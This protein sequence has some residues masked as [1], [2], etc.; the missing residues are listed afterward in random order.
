MNAYSNNQENNDDF[1][2]DPPTND[3]NINAHSG[4]GK[5]DYEFA[6]DTP[7]EGEIM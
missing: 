7:I 6:P 4:D 3:E 5:N 2:P 1:A